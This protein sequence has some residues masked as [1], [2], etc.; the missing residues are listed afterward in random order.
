MSLEWILAALAA[1]IAVGLGTA[2]VFG[3]FTRR[4]DWPNETDELAPPTVRHLRPRKRT[5]QVG[6]RSAAKTPAKIKSGDEVR[7]AVSGT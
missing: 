6:V 1:W 3:T 4:Y 2:F 5:A 7:Q